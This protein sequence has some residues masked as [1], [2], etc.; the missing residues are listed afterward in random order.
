M[1]KKHHR[2]SQ[3]P[4]SATPPPEP[5]AMTLAEKYWSAIWWGT[6]RLLDARYPEAARAVTFKLQRNGLRV[7]PVRTWKTGTSPV[8]AFV[9]LEPNLIHNPRDEDLKRAEAYAS[10]QSA[11]SLR[12]RIKNPRLTNREVLWAYIAARPNA[13][14]DRAT[15]HQCAVARVADLFCLG[16]NT[17]KTMVKRARGESSPDDL[18]T[19]L[20]G[21]AVLR[22]LHRD[23]Y[24]VDWTD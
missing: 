13:K 17:V 10:D 24:G 14:K 7:A 6:W 3:P 4:S 15:P 1:A 9:R 21:V 11:P 22:D 2:I 19:F 5:R 23:L 8:K 16:K 12:G 20:R 18:Q